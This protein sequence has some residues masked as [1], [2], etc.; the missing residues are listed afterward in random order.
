MANS[1]GQPRDDDPETQTCSQASKQGEASTSGTRYEVRAVRN[2]TA[3]AQ[4]SEGETQKKKVAV[5]VAH[6]M[7]Q[8]IP[9]ETLDR[10]AEGLCQQ[11]RAYSN[12]NNKRDVRSVKFENQ[13]LR[14]IELHLRSSTENPIEVHVYEG[15]WAPL[16]EG[17]ITLR[18]VMS[19]LG[20]AGHNGIKN[21]GRNFYRWLFGKYQRF[22]TPIR[23]VLYLL[24]ALVT[25]A[26]LVVMN[27]TIALVAASRTLLADTPAWLSKGLFDDLTTTFNLVVT[28]M[29]V[30]G[31]SLGIAYWLPWPQVPAWA[32]QAWG[33]LVILL[34]IIVQFVVVLAA[35]SLAFLF[36]GHLKWRTADSEQFWHRLFSETAINGFNDSFDIGALGLAIVIGAFFLLRW[37]FKISRGVVRDLFY[38]H[39]RWLTLFVTICLITLG[40]F[41]LCLSLAFLNIFRELSDDNVMMLVPSGLAWPIL[42]GVSAFIRHL[43][44]QYIGDVAIYVAPYKLD[45]FFE[46]RDQVKKYVQKV[47]HAVYAQPRR[48]GS[49]PEYEQIFV[50]GH[51]LGSVIVY[52]VLN[53]LVNDDE[54]AGNCLKVIDRTPLLLTFGSPLDKTAF[55]FAG[56]RKHTHEAREALAASVQPLIRD[57]KFRPKRW[58]NIYSPYDVISGK[59]DF[60]DPPNSGDTRRVCN[61]LDPDA[62]TLLAAHVEYWR[63]NALLFRRLYEALCDQQ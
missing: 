18:A 40:I 41:G 38:E 21:G 12:T 63:S 4:L 15:Y 52:D 20:G 23:I 53:T 14:R 13:W 50:V 47:A 8:Q 48:D 54:A 3:V 32:R 19:F 5:F 51:S 9:F 35:L 33:L 60:Y 46:L 59:L 58:I 61:E 11:D 56:Q 36:Y 16:T 2:S 62:T 42:I 17:K 57:Y 44:I 39:N 25:V 45:S 49:G 55:I 1:T 26:A 22:D 10:V 24:I 28:T 7:G 27:S 6:G 34:F 30:F 37:I 29:A 31:V 43:L